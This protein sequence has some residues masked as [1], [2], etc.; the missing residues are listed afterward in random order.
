MTYAYLVDLDRMAFVARYPSVDEADRAGRKRGLNYDVVS[1]GDD[2]NRYKLK[3]LVKLYN[4]VT[5]AFLKKF[6]N[7]KNAVRRVL[8]VAGERVPSVTF[9]AEE[10]SVKTPDV[11]SS[12]RRSVKAKGTY[13][14]VL[15]RL[16]PPGCTRRFS[17]EHVAR[18]METS[19]KNANVAVHVAASSKKQK[20]PMPIAYFR[21]DRTVRRTDV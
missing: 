1:D 8:V 19:V 7:K 17:I 10:L 9:D 11:T 16:L 12:G 3:E 13:R 18:A 15:E 5:G 4:G 20:D 21:E 14:S 6:E 2:L